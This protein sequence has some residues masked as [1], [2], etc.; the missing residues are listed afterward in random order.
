MNVIGF[1]LAYAPSG[2][3]FA[4]LA[5]TVSVA[6]VIAMPPPLKERGTYAYLYSFLHTLFPVSH[7]KQ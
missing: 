3:T 4:E 2:R 7:P 5:G 1:I 6:A